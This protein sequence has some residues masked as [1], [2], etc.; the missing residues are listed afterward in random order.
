MKNIVIALP[1]LPV[2]MGYRDYSFL[3]L[4]EAVLLSAG[5][6]YAPT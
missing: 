2:S 6:E 4:R 5:G 3:A 1:K